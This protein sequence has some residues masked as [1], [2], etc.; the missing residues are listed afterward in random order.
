MISVIII[1]YNRLNFLVAALESVY[2]QTLKPSEIIV[3]DDGSDYC[4]E[5]KIGPTARQFADIP[6]QFLRLQNSGPSTARNAGAQISKGDILAFLDDDDLWHERY[7]ETS[8]QFLHDNHLEVVIT[9]MDNIRNGK[10]FSGKHISPKILELDLFIRNHGVTGS[11]IVIKKS[12]FEKV[13]GFDPALYISEDKDFLIRAV[14]R[15]KRVGVLDKALVYHGIH[16][17][18]QLSDWEGMDGLKISAKALFLKKHAD[19]MPYSTFRY[20]SGQ[21]GYFYFLGGEGPMTKLKGLA[22]MLWYY[23]KF[24]RVALREG[25]NKWLGNLS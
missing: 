16:G 12:S 23:P 20:L 3:V 8:V 17:E 15:R 5:E 7:L 1:T 9:W 24:F 2:K 18:R 6:V 21:V 11:N 10:V 22:F 13:G 19:I 25:K 4:V 14:Q